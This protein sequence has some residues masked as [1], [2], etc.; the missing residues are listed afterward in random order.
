ML[1]NI[2]FIR[3]A[4]AIILCRIIT[5]LPISHVV[6]IIIESGKWLGSLSILWVIIN[7]VIIENE[8]LGA[9]EDIIWQKT[10]FQ[11]RR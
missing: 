3:D 4:A 7:S 11:G 9:F 10:V 5:L 6:G 8:L 1:R 2:L